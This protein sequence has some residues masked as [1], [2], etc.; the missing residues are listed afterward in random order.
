MNTPL[1]E[2]IKA[3]LAHSAENLDAETK[4]R[5]LEIRRTA[6]K[7]AEKK[8]WFNIEYFVP[9]ASLAFCSVMAVMLFLPAQPMAP[10]QDDIQSE[11]TAMLEL[12]DNPD[13]LETL[14][15]PG[16]YL[17][18]DEAAADDLESEHKH[19]A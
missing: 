8:S 10:M 13:D 1:E 12:I 9:A 4:M 6:L 18:L 3:N 11:P 19:A 14:S 5:L 7:P 2:R 17:W 15:D 16:F